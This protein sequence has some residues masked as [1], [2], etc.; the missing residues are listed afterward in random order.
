MLNP[1]K[2]TTTAGG[3]IDGWWIRRASLNSQSK[4]LLFM[5]NLPQ[6][7]FEKLS[8]KKPFCC[9]G[10]FSFSKHKRDPA[11]WL[12]VLLRIKTHHHLTEMIKPLEHTR[13]PHFWVGLAA[14]LD[15]CLPLAK[16]FKHAVD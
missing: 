8:G 5:K 2:H 3:R 15:T 1:P 4:L 9:M 14:A 6:L 10:F 16:A 13:L 11:L 7:G 12:R